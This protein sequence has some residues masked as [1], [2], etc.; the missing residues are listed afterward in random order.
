MSIIITVNQDKLEQV[1]TLEIGCINV[2]HPTIIL[3]MNSV[4]SYQHALNAT[5]IHQ[6]SNKSTV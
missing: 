6:Y 3:Q 5:T 1:A 4:K 2:C